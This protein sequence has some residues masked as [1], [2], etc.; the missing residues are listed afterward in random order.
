M[1]HHEAEKAAKAAKEA[2]RDQL[3]MMIQDATGIDGLCS[4]RVGKRGRT[5]R[6]TMKGDEE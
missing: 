5:F 4:W 2:A 1:H 6:V 3:C